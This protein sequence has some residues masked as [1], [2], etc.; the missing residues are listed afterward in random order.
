MGNSNGVDRAITN[1]ER[2]LSRPVEHTERD[3]FTRVKAERT[4]TAH[5]RE[6]SGASWSGCFAGGRNWSGGR[7]R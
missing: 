2:E 4:D 1:I 6:W 3:W 7:E 5:E